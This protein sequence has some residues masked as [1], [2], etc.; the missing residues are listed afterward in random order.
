MLNPEDEFIIDAV[1]HPYNLDPSNYADVP[2]ATV[3]S[4]TAYTIG[5]M[6]SPDPVYDIPHDAYVSDWSVSDLANLLFKETATDMGSVHNL[7]LYCYAD[8]MV[9]LEKTAEAVHTWPDR[10]IAYAGIDPLQQTLADFD[11]QIDLLNQPT[12]LKLYP[13]SWNGTTVSQWGMNDPKVIF[14]FYERALEH[15]VKVIAVHKAVPLGPVVTDDA[16]NPAD[17]EAAA[18][19]FPDLTFEIVHGGISFAEE[20][21]WLLARFPNIYINLEISNVILER[22]PRTFS[23]MLLEWLKVGGMPILDRLVWGT[24]CTRAH[25]RPTIDAFCQYEIPEDLLEDAGLFGPLS[26]ITDEHKRGIL[27]TNYAGIHGIDIEARKAAIA[28][29][30]FS[31]AR[32]VDARPVPW[33]T[34]SKWDLIERERAASG[35][36]PVLSQS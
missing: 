25:P 26:Q 33:S 2:S 19:A 30:E 9:S 10:F 11:S 13:T 31:R 32:A 3:I 24:G 34:T 36:D 8:G 28:D 21:G 22:R 15:G 4:E 6:G 5:G 1:A 17:I 12:G 7:P 35:A 23:K 20:T 14:P 18:G 27:A 29:D 16:F